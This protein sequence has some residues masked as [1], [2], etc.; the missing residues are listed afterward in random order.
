MAMLKMQC[1]L[2]CCV[3]PKTKLQSVLIFRSGII[4]GGA[5]FVHVLI[6]AK[7]SKTVEFMNNII[8]KRVMVVLICPRLV[9]NHTKKHTCMDMTVIQLAFLLNLGTHI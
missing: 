1:R 6:N 9:F 5:G 2:V 4:C 8:T 7:I 3:V